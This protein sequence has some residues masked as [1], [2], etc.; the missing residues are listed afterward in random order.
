VGPAG[1]GM[2]VRRGRSGHLPRIQPRAPAGRP[3]HRAGRA[4]P[5]RLPRVCVPRKRIKFDQEVDGARV[6]GDQ[7]PH[8]NIVVFLP[9]S[10]KP[11]N[12]E[13]VVF[14]AAFRDVGYVNLGRLY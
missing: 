7:P 13:L 2:E 14:R 9:P 8:G 3:G 6:S 1:V 11:N 5:P 4:A 10:R 12:Q